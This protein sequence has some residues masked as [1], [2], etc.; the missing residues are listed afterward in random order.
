VEATN[1]HRGRKK[2]RTSY[3]PITFIAS[4]EGHTY[5]GAVEDKLIGQSIQFSILSKLAS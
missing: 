2:I 5:D 4:D 1:F 3:S